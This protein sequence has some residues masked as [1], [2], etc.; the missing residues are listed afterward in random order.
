MKRRRG[1]MA[2]TPERN[3]LNGM[4]TGAVTAAIDA[5]MADARRSLEELVG[6]PGIRPDE[7]HSADVQRSADGVAAY[8]EACGLE[9]VR[10]AAATG[11]PPAVIGEW[12]HAEGAP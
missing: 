3:Q 6:I 11:S 1:R 12:L 5:G 4:S 2:G 7:S 10:H 8:L 9:H